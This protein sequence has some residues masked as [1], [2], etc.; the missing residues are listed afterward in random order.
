[1]KTYAD[2]SAW[3]FDY[4][5]VVWTVWIAWFVV[6]EAYT[7]LRYQGEMLTDHLRPFMLSVP[8][9]WWVFFGLWLWLGVHFLAPSWERGLLELVR[10]RL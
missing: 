10:T 9:L 4:T 1:M 7:G 2:W 5:T 8:V 3:D 6:W